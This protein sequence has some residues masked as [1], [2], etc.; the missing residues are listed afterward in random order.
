MSPGAVTARWT[1]AHPGDVIPAEAPLVQIERRTSRGSWEF[2][3]WDDDRN[4]EIR[5]RGEEIGRDVAWEGRWSGGTPGETYRFVL[6][7]RPW[8][9]T[10]LPEVPG[11]PFVFPPR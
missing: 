4:L 10:W 7:R 2:E 3:C 5:C 9:D 11:D 6:L 8:R 1:D